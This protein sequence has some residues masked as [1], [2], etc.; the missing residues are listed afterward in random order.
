MTAEEKS[1]IR[2]EMANNGLR[3]ELDTLRKQSWFK[4][5]MANWKKRTLGDIGT[6]REQ[7]PNFYKAIDQAW[8]G[9]VNRAFAKMEA[10]REETGQK[11][12]ELNKAKAN[13]KAGNYNLNKP[14]TAEE[15]APFDESGADQ[16]YQELINYSRQ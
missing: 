4:S 9:S 11:V 16:V 15:F 6:D 7:W 10:S 2:N 8:K 3:Q 12:I 13:I 5:D 1:F 14:L